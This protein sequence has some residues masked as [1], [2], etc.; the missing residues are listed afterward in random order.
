MF[1]TA[2][3]ALLT[4]LTVHAPRHDLVLEVARTPAER[5]HGLMDR[6]VLPLHTGMLFVFHADETVSFWMKDTLVPLDMVFVAADGRVRKV[7]ANVP[8]VAPSLPDDRIPLE[9]AAGQ[10]VIELPSGEAASDGI[11]PGVQLDL[12]DAPAAQ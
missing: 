7:F 11:A 3:L 2:A 8:V 5:E 12:H 1:D 4:T 6:K 10:Y 9:T